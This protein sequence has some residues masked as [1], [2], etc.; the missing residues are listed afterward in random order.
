MKEKVCRKFLRA[1]GLNSVAGNVVETLWLSQ[2]LLTVLRTYYLK[3]GGNAGPAQR[4]CHA[5]GS[6]SRLACIVPTPSYPPDYDIT[7]RAVL[8]GQ[9][10][11]IRDNDITL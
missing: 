8:L 9:S 11:D 3:M 5:G 4:C 2:N 1:V 10:Q 6:L 7:P